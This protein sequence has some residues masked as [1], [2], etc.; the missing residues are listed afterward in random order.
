MDEVADQSKPN[1]LKPGS[2]EAIQAGCLC[3]VGDNARGAGYL[4]VPGVYV[5]VEGCPL[6]WRA[7]DTEAKP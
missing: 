4:G 7:K 5:M 1:T 3:P 6:H 2:S